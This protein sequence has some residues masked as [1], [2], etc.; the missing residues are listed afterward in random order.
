MRRVCRLALSVVVLLALGS[1]AGTGGMP[2]N[3]FRD[4][5]VPETFLPYSD[6]WLFIKSPTVTAAKLVYMTQLDMEAAA[7]AVRGALAKDG[8][9]SQ[10]M[11]RGVSRDG[12]RSVT[13]DFTK[14]RDSCRATVVEG[15]HATHV[16]L[17]VARLTTE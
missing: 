14:G 11:N 15:A 2:R 5:T 7:A 10:A 13:M 3:P 6:Q 16:D 12:F 1:C 17:A 8:W 9:V 4:I